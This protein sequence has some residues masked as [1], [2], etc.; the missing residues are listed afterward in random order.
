MRYVCDPSE[1]R[2]EE[3]EGMTSREINRVAMRAHMI[4]LSVEG[5]TGSETVEI[6]DT[7]DIAV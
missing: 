4:P 1:A 5:Y 2:R 6:H 7:T 3:F